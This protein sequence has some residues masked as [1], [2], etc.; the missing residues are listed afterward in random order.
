MIK[1]ERLQELIKQGATIYS[2]CFGVVYEEKLMSNNFVGV[3]DDEI[4]LMQRYNGNEQCFVDYIRCLFETKEDAEWHKE[5][6]HIERTERLDLPTWEE[7][8]K[9][10]AFDFLDKDGFIW[11]IYIDGYNRIIMANGW[12]HFT[13]ENNKEG[14]L[15]TCRKAK[16]L[17][18][19]ENYEN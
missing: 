9:D 3:T 11:E 6:G 8:Q 12:E 18:L 7:W 1:K 16:E 10:D 15:L 14:Y 2:V 5:F 4:S 13:F 17:F 19:G